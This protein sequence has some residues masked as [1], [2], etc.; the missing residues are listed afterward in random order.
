MNIA[1]ITARL[2]SKRIKN[3]NIKI[4]DNKPI[5]AFTIESAIKSNCF[6]KIIVSTNS[7]EIGNIAKKYGA[8]FPFIR[9][10]NLATDN[11]PTSDVIIHAINSI[12][13]T[14]ETNICLLY[15]AS[16]FILAKDLIR[17]NNM[18]DKNNVDFIIAVTNYPH[19]IQRAFTINENKIIKV[20]HS[21]NM[22]IRTQ[23]FEPYYHDAGQFIWATA[24]TWINNIDIYSANNMGLVI[25]SYR[26]YDIDSED[27]WKRAEIMFKYLQYKTML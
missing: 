15:P 18:L 23:E 5:I 4:F 21:K 9:P 16:P 3:K 1:I 26:S 7:L 22:K 11:S 14:D 24:K 19:P 8:E 12:K 17:G 27:D 6:D 10:N 2:G 20:L 13:C 25:P